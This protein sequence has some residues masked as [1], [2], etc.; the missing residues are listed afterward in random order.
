MSKNSHRY[1]NDIRVE[2]D[3]MDDLDE[4]EIEKFEKFKPKKQVDK[5][6]GKKIRRVDED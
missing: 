6:K 3:D 2:V 4:I 5:H 1:K